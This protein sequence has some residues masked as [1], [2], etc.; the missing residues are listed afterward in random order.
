MTKPDSDG[1]VAHTP[2]P[3]AYCGAD[4]GG[5]S[6]MTV[7]GEDHPIATVTSGDWGD[8]YPS[9]RL[10][11]GSLDRGVEAYMEQTTYGNVPEAVAKANA[12]L[13]AAAPD[14]LEA[15][16]AVTQSTE[17]PTMERDTQDAVLAAI[18]KAEA[19]S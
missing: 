1:E 8:D 19:A 15:L 12:R 13:I 10:T 3:W 2:G 5:C 17:W 4:R 11:G 16:K 9:L 7:M 6:C 18:A 14:L